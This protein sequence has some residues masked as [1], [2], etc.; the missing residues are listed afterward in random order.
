M[1]ITKFFYSK[2]QESN[3]VVYVQCCVAQFQVHG[4][5]VRQSYTSQSVPP[6]TSSTHLAPYVVIAMLLT[7]FPKLH[8]TSPGLFWNCQFVPL[9]PFAFLF[10]QPPILLHSGTHE[11]TVSFSSAITHAPTRTHALCSPGAPGRDCLSPAMASEARGQ[12]AAMK[13]TGP[14]GGSRHGSAAP[15]PGHSQPRHRFITKQTFRGRLK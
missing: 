14:K 3:A 6:D 9:N 10:T 1:C 13:S 2:L 8:L 4:V 5:V 12:L 11:F 15:E 7:R